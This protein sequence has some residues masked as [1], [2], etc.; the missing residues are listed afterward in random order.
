MRTYRSDLYPREQWLLRSCGA[1]REGGLNVK[2]RLAR[3]R[4]AG[5]EV[6]FPRAHRPL[7][8][9]VPFVAVCT[10]LQITRVI[11]DICTRIPLS[12][13]PPPLVVIIPRR[14]QSLEPL[15]LGQFGG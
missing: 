11:Y 14:F 3:L 12:P 1:S 5:P 15:E 2:R 4:S 7:F 8:A 13:S 10:R 6:K 9:Q